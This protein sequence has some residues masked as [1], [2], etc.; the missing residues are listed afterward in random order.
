MPRFREADNVQWGLKPAGLID[1]VSKRLPGHEATAVIGKNVITPIIEIRAVARRVWSDQYARCGPQRM[2][3]RQR[4]VFKHIE[5]CPCD[6][7]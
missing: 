5:R 4:L 2:I 3:R 1:H 7:A 6:I